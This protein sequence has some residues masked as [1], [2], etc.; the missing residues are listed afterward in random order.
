MYS[1]LNLSEGNS[2]NFSTR[3]DVT[4]HR[5]TERSEQEAAR[6]DEMVMLQHRMDLLRSEQSVKDET[7]LD[8]ASAINEVYAWVDKEVCPPP[9][10]SSISFF[11]KKRPLSRIDKGRIDSTF[12]KLPSGETLVDNYEAASRCLKDSTDKFISSSNVQA[13]FN[14]RAYV[15]YDGFMS[16]KAA[17]LD[18]DASAIGM[19]ETNSINLST[20]RVKSLSNM[21][22]KSLQVLNLQDFMGIALKNV[23][24]SIPDI[25]FKEN[26]DRIVTAIIRS[27]NDCM[28]Q[29]MAA[30]LDVE[31]VR[32]Q[33][34]VRT[35]NQFQT[36]R[37]DYLND[38]PL[39]NEKMFDDKICNIRQ[40][41]FNENNNRAVLKSLQ[42]KPAA[43]FPK[44]KTQSA[45]HPRGGARGRGNTRGSGRSSSTGH[46]AL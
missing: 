3:G 22:H 40:D 9:P 19:S 21:L 1:V 17:E 15:T 28:G 12:R 25:K 45:P 2:P 16:A 26:L 32:R 41:I 18:K 5:L 30:T 27:N 35:S 42:A 36:H 34:V 37:V 4:S 46:K 20:K 14:E 10:A 24:D 39:K 13:R 23:L 11:S 43:T 31:S 38:M 29:I 7:D 8:M 44:P 33:A 6:M